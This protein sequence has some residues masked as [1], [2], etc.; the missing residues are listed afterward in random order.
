MYHTKL[1]FAIGGIPISFAVKSILELYQ[2]TFTT[3]SFAM[4]FTILSF[5]VEAY[6][7]IIYNTHN[8][9]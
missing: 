1:S 6:D 8:V 3:Y 2:S 5:V 4:D 7:I 9:S